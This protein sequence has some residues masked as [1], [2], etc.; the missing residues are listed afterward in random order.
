MEVNGDKGQM[1][2]TRCT[3]LLAFNSPKAKRYLPLTP[4]LLN[5]NYVSDKKSNH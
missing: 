2:C 3:K 4:K 1:Y 5:M